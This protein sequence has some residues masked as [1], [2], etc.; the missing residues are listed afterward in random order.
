MITIII[1]CAFRFRTILPLGVQWWIKKNEPLAASL[2]G[3]SGLNP[4]LAVLCCLEN[5]SYELTESAL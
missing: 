3:R 4:A 5:V 2:V 1:T